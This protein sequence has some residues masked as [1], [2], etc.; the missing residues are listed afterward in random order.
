[1][2]FNFQTKNMHKY[3]YVTLSLIGIFWL[4]SLTELYI[5][6][7][8]G[9]NIPNIK[10]AIAYKLLNDF[11]L[12][13]WIGFLVF[14]LYFLL[15]LIGK[16]FGEIVI[17]VLFVLFVL[18]QFSLVKY[19]LTTL[20]P[21]GA[22]ILGYSLKDIYITIT[23]SEKISV[24]YFLP[25]IL[26]PLLLL[27]INYTFNKTANKQKYLVIILLLVLLF[28]SLKLTLPKASNIAYQNKIQYLTKDIIRYLKEQK[29]TR[30]YNLLERNDYPFLK[31]FSETKDVLSPFFNIQKEKPTIVILIVEGLG[32]EFV[33]KNAYSGFTPYLDSLISKSLYWEN[34]VSTSGRTF[35]VLPSLLASLPYGEKGFLELNNIPSHFSLISVLNAN[36]YT[37]SFYSG[38]PSSFDK[39]INF[40]EYNGIDYIIDEDKFGSEYTKTE[41]NSGG[42]SWGYP[43]SE[44]FRKTLNELD[45]KKLPRLD[46]IMTLT[47]HE[48]FEFPLRENYLTK[49]D[50]I[51]NSNQIFGIQKEEIRTHKNIYASLLYTDNSIKNFMTAFAKREEYNNTIFIITGDHRLIPITQ[52]DKLCRFHVPLF[53]YSP[54]LKK[55]ES[56]KSISS[57][58]D[59]TPSLL[60]FLMNNYTFNKLEKVA[61]IGQGL[62]TAKHFRNIHQIPLM[63]YKGIINDFIYKD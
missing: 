61:W 56:F 54:M 36:G 32:S 3:I 18:I 7:S 37:T 10:T 58:L 14:P 13:M 44:I 27:G 59:V 5:T 15:I 52:K 34:F 35:G 63:R 50:S 28:G 1:M 23:S 45:K 2:K 46:I 9:I 48:P 39:K 25:F 31:P 47:N 30:N 62:D 41:G 8:N 21:L 11:W 53:I 22:D 24:L 4:I 55:A 6:I 43:D 19:S 42:F 16:R 12:G 51:L 29:Q 49:V 60:S 57:H 26:F 38:D 40:L 33:G 20:I 17:K